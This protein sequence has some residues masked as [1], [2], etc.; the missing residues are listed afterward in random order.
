MLRVVGNGFKPFRNL[1]LVDKYIFFEFVAP[2]LFS[3]GL[4]LA[5][6][7]PG[8][9]LFNLIDLLVK[10]GISFKLFMQL[11]SY[12]LPEMLF[13]SFPMS[14]L[15]A[16][17]LTS[18]RLY[19]DNEIIIFQLS[20]RTSFR[21]FFPVFVF[22][23]LLSFVSLFF[24]DLVVS[25]SNAEFSRNYLYAQLKK[26]LPVSKQNIFYKEYDNTVLKRAFYARE[27]TGDIMYKPVVEEF[28]H[29]VL[30]TIIEA[31]KGALIQGRWIF[32]QGTIYNIGG[33][34]FR[35]LVNF[36]K[37]SISFR[38][39][40]ENIAREART[41]KEMNFAELAGHIEDLKT[42][43][44]KTGSLEVQLH[45]KIAVPFTSVLF[46]MVGIP[47]GFNK[48]SKTSSFGFS[49]SIL[50]IFAYYIIMFCCTALG[51]IEVLNPFFCAWLPDILV[52]FTGLFLFYRKIY[53]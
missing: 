27:F 23:L 13:Y 38:A 31:E 1:D 15:L 10:Y 34:N 17:L 44:E 50:F 46:F 40:L 53:I 42:A 18:S 14:V 4:F 20:G 35:S 39:S 16:S 9:V 11:F 32:Y 48:K 25:K 28:E 51:S 7:I 41:P 21:L 45:Q 5:I 36:E 19:R 3:L 8:F 49:F 12:S 2:F 43:G 22:T 30:K 6:T 26:N 47:L 33:K 24:N 29:G 37:Y 52:F